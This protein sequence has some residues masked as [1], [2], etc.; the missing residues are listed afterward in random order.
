MPNKQSPVA[1]KPV[2]PSPKRGRVR[3]DA[4]AVAAPV[5]DIAPEVKLPKPYW[6]YLLECR[7]GSWYAGIALDVQDRFKKHVL[8]KGA[9]YTRANPPLRVLASIVF[10]CKGDALRAEYAVKQLPKRRKLD[11]FQAPR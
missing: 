2:Q 1:I 5:E 9:A 3:K 11:F 7:G 4:P 10:P 6:L 8:G